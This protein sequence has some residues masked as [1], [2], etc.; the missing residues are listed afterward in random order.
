MKKYLSLLFLVSSFFSY[1]QT[2][3]KFNGASALALITNVGIETSIG[4]KMTFQFD[5]TGSFWESVNG[6]PFKAVILT[7]EVRYHFKEK[8]NG[9]YVGANISGGTFELQKY[10]YKN[11]DYYQKGYNYMLGITLG[12]QWKLSDKWAL[13]L[14]VG[15]GHQEAFYKGYL[16]STGERYDTWIHNY[17]KSGEW[18]LYRGGLMIAYKI[19]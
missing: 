5:A 11:T 1:S 12:Y 6:A 7:P 17:N 3:V 10:G 2:Y 15:G 8:N 4:K 13:D 9:F 14:F 16:L 19:K 18:I